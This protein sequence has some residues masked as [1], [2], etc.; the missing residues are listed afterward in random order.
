MSLLLACREKP[1]QQVSSDES[2]RFVLHPLTSFPLPADLL[3]CSGVEHTADSSFWMHN[4]KGNPPLLYQIDQQGA[5]IRTLNIAGFDNNDWEDLT[6]DDDHLYIGDF[7][8]NKNERTNLAVLLIAQPGKITTSQIIPEAI[9]FS[10]KD[11]TQFPPEKPDKLFDCEAFFAH[12]GRLYLFIKDRTKP[13]QGLTRLYQLDATPG[14][15]QAVPV[16]DFRTSDR[17]PDGAITGADISP[18]GNMVALISTRQLWLFTDF[19][20]PDVFAGKVDRL[21]IPDDRKFEGVV[22]TSNCTLCLTNEKN[23]R[24]G[25]Q[26]QF[27]NICK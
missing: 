26:M 17:K 25:Q 9:H 13:F 14:I 6:S 18:D 22:F 2:G 16:S 7:G 1:S 23:K 10:F 5:E 21:S 3:E 4:D 8:N 15:Q 12:N 27:F 20:L 24:A 11:Q 19:V